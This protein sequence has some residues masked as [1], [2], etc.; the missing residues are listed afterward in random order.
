VV[1][2]PF[3]ECESGWNIPISADSLE[4]GAASG[5]EMDTIDDNNKPDGLKTLAIA[6]DGR[7]YM[8]Y[9]DHQGGGF[10]FSI[11]SVRVGGSLVLDGVLQQIVLRAIDAA[12]G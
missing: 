10:V 2:D 4:R 1:G 12:V 6:K 11:G 5:V 7:S 8:T 9:Y 3:G